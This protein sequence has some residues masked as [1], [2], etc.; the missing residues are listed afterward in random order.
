[1]TRKVYIYNNGDYGSP[2]WRVETYPLGTRYV[3][4]FAAVDLLPQLFGSTREVTEVQCTFILS[5]DGDLLFD[6]DE[7]NK[8]LNDPTHHQ[9]RWLTERCNMV[10]S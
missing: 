5:I 4:K 1:M 2:V 9:H 6:A 3:T 8:I 10:V 7:R